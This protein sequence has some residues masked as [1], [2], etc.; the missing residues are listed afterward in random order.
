MLLKYTLNNIF[1]K[2]GRLFIILFCTIVACFSAYMA[3]DFGQAIGDIISK[4]IAQRFG[5]ADYLVYYRGSGGITDDLFTDVPEVKYVSKSQVTRREIRRDEKLYSYALVDSISFTAYSDIDTAMSL[6]LFPETAKPE[7]GKVTINSKYAEKYGYKEGDKISFYD[8]DGNEFSYEI[9]GIFSEKNSARD[10]FYGYITSDDIKEITKTKYY[11]VAYVDVDDDLRAEFEEGMKE[12]HP[13]AS[14]TVLYS[15][16]GV[17][18][19][20]DKLT[21]IFYLVFVMMFLL[22]VFVTVSF[23]EK[24][25]NE[26]MSVIGTLRSIGVSMRKTA[27]ILLFENIMYAVIGSGLGF[28]LY[29][30]VR[31]LAIVFLAEG[32]DGFDI[33][34]ISPLTVILV[35]LGAI[36]VQLL[37]PTLEMLKA[38]KTSI[39]DI[40]FDTR[41]SEYKLSVPRTIIGAACIII[42]FLV[43]FLSQNLYLTMI[44]MIVVVAGSALCLPIVLRKFSEISSGFFGKKGKP[45]AELAATEAGSKKHNFGS[46]ILAVASI[47]V[48][49]VVFVTAISLLSAFSAPKY[50]C[51]VVVTDAMLKTNKYDFISE[52]E[53]VDSVA[54]KY[55]QEGVLN[56]VGYGNGQ[57]SGISVMAITDMSTYLGM[58]ELPDSIEDGEMIINQSAARKFGASVGDSVKLVF[59]VSEIFPIEKELVV[60]QITSE[61]EFMSGSVII[62]TPELY[63]DVY[64]DQPSELYIRTS[65]PYGV[66]EELENE[67]TSGET[68]KTYEDILEET[69]EDNKSILFTLLGVIIVS[70]VLSLIGISG[71]QVISFSARKKEYAM[72][73]SCACPLKK[74]IRMIWI[75]NG[76]VFGVSGIIAFIMCI[77]LTMLASKA[78]SLA[79]L[80]ITVKVNPI[81]LLLYIIILW[82]ITMLTALTPIKSLKKMN[83]AAEMKYE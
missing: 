16:G 21:S 71:N 42:G 27:F 80:G 34:P 51:D 35:V 78:F 57:V 14:L 43:G 24:I 9:S 19:E 33:G 28:I 31:N 37:L 6:K 8:S 18:E 23:T 52:K 77:P 47:L 75:E 39:R 83:T 13:N 3:A 12:K 63:K 11:Y 15:T 22:V 7:K 1:Q 59:H 50:N 30:I 60:K 68:I 53:S 69:K 29:M 74:I 48:T 40:I 45:V 61:S 46:S 66:E 2:K 17:M 67:L 10:E 4:Q 32:D 56:D 38:V 25:I 81:L 26:R 65:D 79:D 72:L 49:A 20:I 58:G 70:V 64:T 41:D 5:T 55:F 36:A 44:S 54:V 76:L 82:I 62:I 73:H